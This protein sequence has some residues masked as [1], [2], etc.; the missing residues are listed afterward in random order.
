MEDLRIT[1]RMIVFQLLQGEQMLKS[2][3]TSF[4]ELDQEDVEEFKHMLWENYDKTKA[5]LELPPGEFWKVIQSGKISDY[6]VTSM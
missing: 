6:I 4:E 2:L 3:G 1:G 5:V